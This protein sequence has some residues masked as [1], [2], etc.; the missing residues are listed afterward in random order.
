MQ[1][2]LEPPSDGLP[3]GSRNND[4]TCRCLGLQPGRHIYSVAIDVGT[5]DNDVAEMQA[6][7]E[8]DCLVLGLAT[9][10]LDHGLLEVDGG[11]KRVH[12]ARELYKCAIA[13]DADHPSAA[14]RH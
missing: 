14:T 5:V 2:D 6:D 10:G 8:D 3:H 1:R 11:G 9:I 13:L 4:P 12:R 7:P